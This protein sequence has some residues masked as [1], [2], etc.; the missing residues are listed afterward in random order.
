MKLPRQKFTNLALI[1]IALA[2]FGLVLWTK[3]GVTT[4]EQEARSNNLLASWREDDLTSIEIERGKDKLRV[5]RREEPD[6]GDS[7]W[8]LTAPLDE[9]ADISAVTDLI[10]SLGFATPVRRI[11]PEEVDRAAF[12]LDAPR[13]VMHIDLG[14]VRYRLALGKEAAAPP[15]SAYLEVSGDGAPRPG[16]AIVSRDLIK[17]LDVDANALRTREIIPYVSSALSRLEVQGPGGLRKLRRAEWGGWR[18]DGMERDL[19]VNRDALDRILLQFARTKVEQFIDAG[20]AERALAGTS[21]V[22]ITMVHED[23]KKPR[24]VIEVGGVCPKNANE[25][26]ALRREPEPLAAC[27][28]KSVMPGLSTPAEELVDRSLFTLRTD[29]V[30]AFVSVEADKRLELE[31]KEKGFVMRAPQSGQ[32]ELEP[33]NQRIQSMLATRGELVQDA[34]PADLGLDP[35]RGSVLMRSTAP[36]ESRVVEE[37]ISIGKA[38]A[39]GR[40][41]VQRKQDGAVLLIDAV[42]AKSLLPDATLDAKSD[43]FRIFSQRSAGDRDQDAAHDAKTPAQ[44][45]G[46]VHARSAQGIRRGSRPLQRPGR[47]AAVARRGALGGRS[48]RRQLRTSET[49]RPA[50]GRARETRRLAQRT[51]GFH[52]DSDR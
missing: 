38:A 27:A 31:R 15:G 28:P 10:G 29:E 19:R 35:P 17:Q 16:V 30:E 1:A 8:F 22:R 23:P 32:I 52:R 11:K 26:V 20:A 4:G 49:E 5:E 47:G 44:L 48:G 39:D 25:V 33:G 50:L 14:R 34:K 41:N 36:L 42:S 37:S 43:N 46:N 18:F 13:W 51:R 9:E 7:S 24:A 3:G 40:V 2:L 21:S 45:V 6:G 12:G